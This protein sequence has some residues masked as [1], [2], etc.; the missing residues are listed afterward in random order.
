MVSRRRHL[1]A[2]LVVAHSLLLSLSLA[3]SSGPLSFPSLQLNSPPTSSL[4]PLA[5]ALTSLDSFPV[6]S[7]RDSLSLTQ[8]LL[9]LDLGTHVLSSQLLRENVGL[10]ISPVSGIHAHRSSMVSILYI[11]SK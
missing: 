8:A 7:P 2:A 6:L 10:G 3:S 1:G 4:P 11:T 9:S 5:S